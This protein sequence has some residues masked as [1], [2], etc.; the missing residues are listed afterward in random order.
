M[1][2]AVA[3]EVVGL[4]DVEA[5]VDALPALAHDAPEQRAALATEGRVLVALCHKVVPLD[6]VHL[7]LLA[8][9]RAIPVVAP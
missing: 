9:E 7:L 3:S 4:V 6:Q 2:L 5:A 1:A 8:E